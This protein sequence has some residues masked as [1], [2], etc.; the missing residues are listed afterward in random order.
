MTPDNKRLVRERVKKYGKNAGYGALIAALGAV[1]G[2]V[3]DFVK[4]KIENSKI[5]HLEISNAEKDVKIAR[6][7]EAVSGMKKEFE[8]TNASIRVL[9]AKL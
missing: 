4:G 5:E 9:I 2:Q 3:K 6:L 7:E 8:N 1:G